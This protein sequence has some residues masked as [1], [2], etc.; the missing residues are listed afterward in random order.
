MTPDL[1]TKVADVLDA[2]AAEKEKLASELQ[3]LQQEN[4]MRQ[5]Q[6]LV[7]K[8]S[9]LQDDS[10]QHKLST[11]DENTLNLISKVA[12]ADVPSLGELH[13][14]ASHGSTNSADTDFA[15]WILS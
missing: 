1:L 6:P 5:L 7:E 9:Y 15:S 4:K 12:G 10:L 3:D 14:T 13:K 2:V 11:L 8:L